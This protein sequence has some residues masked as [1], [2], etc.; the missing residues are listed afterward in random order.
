MIAAARQV[1]QLHPPAP[2]S[3]S[4]TASIPTRTPPT[5]GRPRG[6]GARWEP[7]APA[8]SRPARRQAPGLRRPLRWVHSASIGGPAIADPGRDPGATERRRF[9]AAPAEGA[10]Q[11]SGSLRPSAT[12]PGGVPSTSP[13]DVE[14]TQRAVADSLA[15]R[16]VDGL[17]EALVP[18]LAAS[19]IEGAGRLH[20]LVVRVM[21]MELSASSL[22][23]TPNPLTLQQRAAS[24]DE[25]IGA[26]AQ[27]KTLTESQVAVLRWIGDGCPEGGD[28][29][30][31]FHRISAAAALRRRGF[32]ETLGPRSQLDSVDHRCGPRPTCEKVNGGK[33]ADPE[34]GECVW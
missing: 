5:A 20:Q 28:R 15:Q 22:A 12:F 14:V 18:E 17:A 10:P 6:H 26:V 24:G 31:D 25:K 1:G 34:T 29:G 23:S 13:H 3:T 9:R 27:R 7:G 30:N 19:G 16:R 21:Y 4:R 11:R 33:A 32:V 8:R 2:G